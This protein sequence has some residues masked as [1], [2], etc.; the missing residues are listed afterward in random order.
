VTVLGCPNCGRT[1]EIYEV[2]RV[3]TLQHVSV[4]DAD[5]RY[6]AVAYLGKEEPDWDCWEFA[7]Y[8]C[9]ECGHDVHSSTDLA[10]VTT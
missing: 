4:T 10:P 3:L 7:G 6:P 1:E 8:E 9:G 2:G 5:G